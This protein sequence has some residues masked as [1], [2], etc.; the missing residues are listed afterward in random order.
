[1]SEHVL[2]FEREGPIAIL[3]LNRPDRLNALNGP[4]L[5]ELTSAI[6]KI[7]RD[8]EIRAF[9]VTGA[10]RRDGRPC[11]SAGDDLKEAQ[12]GDMPPGNPG[13]R[14]TNMIDDCWK[15]SIAVIDGI[16]TTGA[17]E[18]AM[19]CHLRVVGESAQISDWHL[20]RLGAGIGGWGASTRLPRLVGLAKAREIILTGM[21][22]EGAEAVRIGLANRVVPS[23]RLFDEAMTMARAI[24]A[25]STEGVRI[26]QAHLSRTLDLSKEES[27]GFAKQVREMMPRS[28]RFQD[29]AKGAL[30]ARLDAE[31]MDR[32][33]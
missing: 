22:V 20:K 13:F 16:C 12:A 24:A 33:A 26:T 32:D 30:D 23:E 2:D 3:R 25:M 18:I 17:L 11:F 15:P 21:V 27:L 31:K 4:L 10:P 5:A 7:K 14:L 1:M 8:D 19:A 29:L 28:E 9:L 6:R